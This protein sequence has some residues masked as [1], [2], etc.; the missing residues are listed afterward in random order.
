MLDLNYGV[1]QIEGRWTIIGRGLRFGAWATAAEAQA[2]ARRLADQAA[3]LPVSLHLQ[4]PSGQ[5]HRPQ[6]QA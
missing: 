1:V 2:A 5:L 3:G 6:P 4:D